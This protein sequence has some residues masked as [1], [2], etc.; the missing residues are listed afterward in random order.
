MNKLSLRTKLY[1]LAGVLLLMC[2]VIGLI[3]YGTSQKISN[4]YSKI[5]EFNY[6]NT[7]NIC[8]WTA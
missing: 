3:G 5:D 4:A 7:K 1:F 8:N 6:P 2:G